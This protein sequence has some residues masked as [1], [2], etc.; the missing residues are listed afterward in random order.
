MNPSL[1]GHATPPD[2]AGQAIN[3]GIMTIIARADNSP[4]TSLRARESDAS[5]T[6]R[7]RDRPWM[8]PLLHFRA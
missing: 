4:F 5:F 1:F 7:F 8:H 6:V 2:R 3:V